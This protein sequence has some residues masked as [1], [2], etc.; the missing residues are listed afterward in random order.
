MASRFSRLA[1]AGALTAFLIGGMTATSF[2]DAGG[3]GKGAEHANEHAGANENAA[4]NPHAAEA[5][6][7]ESSGASTESETATAASSSSSSTSTRGCNQTPYGSGGSGA[8]TGGAYDDTCE[9]APSGNGNGG[10]K[11]TGKPAAGTVGKA[12]E[13]NP[14]GQQPGPNDKNKGYECDGNKGIARTNPAHTGC[15]TTNNPPPDD[16][17][18]TQVEGETLTRVT[19]K[20]TTTG[21]STPATEVL[22][23]VFERPAGSLAVTGTEV[24][25]TALAGAALVLLGSAFVL[26][27]RRRRT[28]ATI[29]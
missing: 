26:A 8:N 6:A 16:E 24:K 7:E 17:T 1:A 9:P 29:D 25:G 14:P 12:D 22:G 15:A 27:A 28:E 5:A 2:A 21:S 10:G 20:T 19:P 11:A 23:V 18:D 3:N 4:N 13:K